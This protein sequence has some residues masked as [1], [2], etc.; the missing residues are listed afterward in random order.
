MFTGIV[1]E[2]G[3]VKNIKRTRGKIV[4][5]IISK[6]ILPRLKIG[7]SVSM[8][9][10]CLTVV[11]FGKDSFDVE[12]IPETLKLTNLGDL[13]LGSGVD[14]E[15]S[16]TLQ[17]ELGGHFV[18]GHIDGMGK[19]IKLQKEG[20]SVLMTIAFSDRLKKYIAYKGSIAVDGV[21]LTV[22]K[23]F[24]QKFTVALIPHTLK[25]TVLS[26]KKLG[27]KVNLEVDVVARHLEKLV[28][29]EK[30][31]KISL[32]FLKRQGF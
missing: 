18:L 7:S 9:G 16:L 13:K 12:V 24:D 26:K 2:L 22:A 21:S 25:V 8:N 1:Q 31:S 29:S 14:L 6:K 20:D 3:K 4:I 10:V 19:V 5:S 27:D 28:S 11:K 17:D 23:I 30:D 32:K 15:P